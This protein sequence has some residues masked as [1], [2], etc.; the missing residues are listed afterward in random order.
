MSFARRSSSGTNIIF[1]P[2]GAVGSSTVFN[3]SVGAGYLREMTWMIR[4]P[5]EKMSSLSV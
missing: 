1:L 3:A 4:T 5:A 2:V